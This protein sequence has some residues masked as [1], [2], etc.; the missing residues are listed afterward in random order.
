MGL[1]KKCT[2]KHEGECP[3]IWEVCCLLECSN[4]GNKATL[5]YDAMF[6]VPD[7]CCGKCNEKLFKP[8]KWTEEDKK[9]GKNGDL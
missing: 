9:K 6:A 8:I 5:A 4:C 3:E 2:F 7:L 1:C